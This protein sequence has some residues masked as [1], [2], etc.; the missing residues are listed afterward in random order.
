METLEQK[1]RKA[2]LNSGLI[3][4]LIFLVLGI[5]TF[6][7]I[8]SLTS[9][10]AILVVPICFSII[11]PIVLVVLFCMDI[12]KKIGGFWTF[13]QAATGIFIMFFAAYIVQSVG[14]DLI[15]AKF[16]EPN[17]VEKTQQA[18]I[19]A[20]TA[21]LEKSGA[22][23]SQI[24]TKIATIQKQFDDQKNIT[25]GKQIQSIGISIIFI[26]VCA[27]IFGAIFK[28]DPPLYAEPIDEGPAV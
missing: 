16:I 3:L 19:N 8:T 12:R 2:S 15:F 7:L 28:K 18:T 10:W 25:V 4:G 27:L 11:I 5:C 17:M 21:M 23:Q 14:R 22:E 6:Y 24:D 26:F 13:K 20:T 1:I 9:M